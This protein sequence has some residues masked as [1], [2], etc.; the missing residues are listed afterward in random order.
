MA[1]LR[2]LLLEVALIST[3]ALRLTPASTGPNRA[4][5]A[6]RLGSAPCAVAISDFEAVVSRRG[7]LSAAAV[8]FGVAALPGMSRA[9][10]IPD[11]DDEI[12]APSSGGNPQAVSVQTV[13][14]GG[15]KKQKPQS[16]Y[17]RIKELQNKG[18]LT[19]KE[20]KELKRLKAEEMCEM[21]GKGC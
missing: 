10:N 2:V 1:T 20:R 5:A 19:D 13:A 18:Q 6:P 11:L 14:A 7:A 17:E 3:A 8:A 21:L 4:T 15:P 16:G 9:A 12:S